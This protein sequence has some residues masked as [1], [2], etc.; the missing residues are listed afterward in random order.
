MCHEF[1]ESLILLILLVPKGSIELA[2]F[3]GLPMKSVNS[4]NYCT[5]KAPTKSYNK[6][7]LFMKFGKLNFSQMEVFYSDEGRVI[8]WFPFAA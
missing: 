2:V 4:L 8:T 3:L 1:G 6:V 5:D 7:R